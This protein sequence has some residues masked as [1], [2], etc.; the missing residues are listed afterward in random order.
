[1]NHNVEYNIL[2]KE[3]NAFRKPQDDCPNEF[4]NGVRGGKSLCIHSYIACIRH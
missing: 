1:M 4:G 2:D 3:R